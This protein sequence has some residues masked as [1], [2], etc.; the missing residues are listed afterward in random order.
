MIEFDM[1]EVRALEVD[2]LKAGL[3]VAMKV[4]PVVAKGAHNVTMDA[5]RTISAQLSAKSHAKHYPGSIT[6]DLDFSG[7]VIGAEIGPDKDRKQGA[8]GNLLEYGSANNAPRAHLGPALDSEAP[9]FEQAI[10]DVAGDV[11]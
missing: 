1:S 3:R 7:G 10:A 9:K 11:F 6:Y 4:T 2:L 5:R 8:L